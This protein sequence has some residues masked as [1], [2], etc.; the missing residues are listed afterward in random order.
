[1]KR[2]RKSSVIGLLE[3]E[4]EKHD[5]NDMEVVQIGVIP[6]DDETVIEPILHACAS[7]I[8]VLDSGVSRPT[9]VTLKEDDTTIFVSCHLPLNHTIDDD[10]ITEVKQ[11]YA[12]VI[13]QF[14]YTAVNKGLIATFL[15]AKN[16][17]CFEYRQTWN[18]PVGIREQRSVISIEDQEARSSRKKSDVGL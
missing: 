18:T 4:L 3:K 13:S 6:I 7:F 16:G 10:R 2:R 15:V 11:N 17:M 8:L 9:K 5:L 14:K 12:D 1:M